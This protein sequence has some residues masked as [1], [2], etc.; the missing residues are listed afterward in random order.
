MFKKAVLHFKTADPIIYAVSL[1]LEPFE[2]S[3]RHKVEDHF[4]ALCGEIIGQQLSGKAADKI[5]SRFIE[6]FPDKKV[7]PEFTV[8]I[9]EE[10]LRE[11]GTSWAKARYIRDLAQR[12]LEKQ[13]HLEKISKLSD[14]EVIIEL[15]KVKG[16]GRWT[17][18]MYLMF[19]LGRQ[20]VFSF[21]DLGLQ[22][23]IKKVYKLKNKPTAKQMEKLS[24]KWAP[25]RTY[26]ARIL[27]ASLDNQPK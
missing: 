17:A 8:K 15:T 23:A 1:T 19:T 24:R 12:V 4:F 13:V 22:N 3:Q 20:D 26:A 11:I 7:T 25:Y 18:E 9:P 6:L 14:E 21:G 2:G 27:W 10:K 16:I 5:F